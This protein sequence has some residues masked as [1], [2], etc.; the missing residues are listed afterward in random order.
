[1]RSWE[2]VEEIPLKKQKRNGDIHQEAG[3]GELAEKAR[4]K[5][6]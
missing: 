1:M 6:G 4:V 5:A 3:V 2:W